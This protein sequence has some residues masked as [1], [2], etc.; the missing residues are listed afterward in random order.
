MSEAHPPGSAQT[1]SCQEPL[2]SPRALP[3]GPPSGR[4]VAQPGSASHWGCGG[5]RFESSRPDQLF[6]MLSTSS[7]V[8]RR[9]KNRLP[10]CAGGANLRNKAKRFA[11]NCNEGLKRQRIRSRT[12][13]SFRAEVTTGSF[14]IKNAIRNGPVCQPIKD[15]LAVQRPQIRAGMIKASGHKSP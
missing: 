8:F 13:R 3:I 7:S 9:G 1:N 11:P 10:W 2:L 14:Q 6:Q 4:D 15:F 12:Q 5:R